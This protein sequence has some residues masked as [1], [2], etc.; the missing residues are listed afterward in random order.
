M[1]FYEIQQQ[2]N[3]A[4][5]QQ[6]ATHHTF[7]GLGQLVH[8]SCVHAMF[9]YYTTLHSFKLA[10]ATSGSAHAHTCQQSV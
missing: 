4:H 2:L 9:N 8:F 1:R 3:A 7:S 6:Q 10:D 5:N